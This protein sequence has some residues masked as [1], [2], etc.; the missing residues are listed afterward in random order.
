MSRLR[1]IVATSISVALLA[2]AGCSSDPP[3]RAAPAPAVTA[4]PKPKPAWTI[5][6]RAVSRPVAVGDRIVVYATGRDKGIDLVGIDP[7]AGEIDWRL[8][9]AP[10]H[11]PPGQSFN[12][13]VH[14]GRVLYL[15][16]A[17]KLSDW[18][19]QLVAID[20]VKGRSVWRSGTG[21]YQGFPEACPDAAGYLCVSVLAD[22]GVLPLRIHAGTGKPIVRKADSS[23]RRQ[24]GPDL[25]DLGR[26]DP[27]YLAKIDI[28]GREHWRRSAA[29]LF[30]G[31]HRSTDQGW[32]FDRYGPLVVGSIGV[33]G[34]PREFSLADAAVAGISSRDG[35]TAWL[36]KGSQYGCLSSIGRSKDWPVRCRFTGRYRSAPRATSADPTLIG[37]SAV[38]E[39]FDP[40]TG[41][42]RWQ[43]A[44]GPARSLLS[45]QG[46]SLVRVDSHTVIIPDAQGG[47]I[48]VDA[49]AGRSSRPATGL[50]GW[51]DRPNK[52]PFAVAWAGIKHR[53]GV[54]L[55]VP[56]TAAGKD[57]AVPLEIY[58]PVGARVGDR[59]VWA[60]PDGLHAVVAPARPTSPEWLDDGEL[61]PH[62]GR[63]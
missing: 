33:G 23:Y 26:R 47:P 52:Y 36:D 35:R 32:N 8:P 48:V 9:A 18:T 16:P 5:P 14:Q 45:L 34:D 43:I 37:Y 40:A 46:T 15:S 13:A 62:G 55:S 7:V 12:V 56:C 27:E 24:V 41:K 21:A 10:P 49:F 11:V 39:G 25:Y 54:D 6:L 2:L 60:A 61:T 1:R 31:M 51:C 22:G 4:V 28:T 38:I 20:P 50:T 42:T 57:L 53:W 63:T 19:A 58:D 29:T 59:F 30:G 17:G 44:A 3:D